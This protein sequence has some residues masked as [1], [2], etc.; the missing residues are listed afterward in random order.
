MNKQIRTYSVFVEILYIKL[1]STIPA[2][3]YFPQVKALVS[4]ALIGLTSLFGMERGG[5]LLL[6]SPRSY[7]QI[8]KVHRVRYCLS[9]TKKLDV[10][11]HK[12]WI[13]SITELC[14]PFYYQRCTTISIA[15]LNTLLYLHLQPI[16]LVFS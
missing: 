13:R 11:I 8:F 3:T 15:R 9:N 6:S 4:S 7:S 12:N 2:T 14:S 1:V 10:F 5:S 16:N